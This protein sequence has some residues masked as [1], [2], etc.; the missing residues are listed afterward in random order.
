M[1]K[2][3][4]AL[5]LSMLIFSSYGQRQL[6]GMKGIYL[7]GGISQLGTFGKLGTTFITGGKTF[8]TGDFMVET[9]TVRSFKF[10]TYNLTGT[11]YYTPLKLKDRFFV[12]PGAGITAS[13]SS[14]KA[15]E[16]SESGTPSDLTQYNYGILGSLQLDYYLS[17]KLVLMGNADQRYYISNKFGTMAWFAGAGLKYFF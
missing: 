7:Q 13:V 9:G 2:V 10:Q 8:A 5:L 1:K 3:F 11:F 12:S 15:V 14:V 16:I 4:F 6:K 17:N